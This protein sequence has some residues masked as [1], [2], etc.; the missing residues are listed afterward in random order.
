MTE[1]P[2]IPLS[3]RPRK[4]DNFEDF[5]IGENQVAVAAVR[6]LIE[7]TLDNP[8]S[9]IYLKGDA[10]SGKSL[11]L[12]AACNRARELG[13]SAIY[14][15]LK[16]LLS[17]PAPPREIT[18]ADV[19]CI[20][21]VEAM[22]ANDS[23]ELFV[24]HLLNQLRSSNTRVLLAGRQGPEH[25]GIVLPDLQSRL[26]W[27]EVFG[28]KV[29][30]D[31]DKKVVLRKYASAHGVEVVDEVLNYLLRYGRRDMKYLLATLN[32]LQQAAFSSKRAPT[33]PLLRTVIK[34][35]NHNNKE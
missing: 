1:S 34:Q 11:L 33:V 7:P 32:E 21:D 35:Q 14:L 2:Q 8:A 26:A 13:Q 10:G 18:G 28:L 12:N 27:G 19:L 15:P 30:T 24:F 16:H 25:S 6:Q 20:D 4:N 17:K 29:L 5:V 3:F 22:A 9:V 31:I 23:W